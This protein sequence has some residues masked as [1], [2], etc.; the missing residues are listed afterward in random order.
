MKTSGV[1]DDVQITAVRILTFAVAH[2]R[3]TR[4]AALRSDEDFPGGSRAVSLGT[5]KSGYETGTRH[6]RDANPTRVANNFTSLA[7]ENS[8]RFKVFVG[9]SFK[10]ISLPRSWPSQNEMMTNNN[11]GNRNSNPGVGLCCPVGSVAAPS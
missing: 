1:K 3:L 11:E 2:A 7:H 5:E 4:T 9:S 8:S 6:S 10:N